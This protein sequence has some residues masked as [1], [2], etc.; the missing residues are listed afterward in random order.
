MYTVVDGGYCVDLY[1]TRKAVS[2]A[3]GGEELCFDRDEPEAL[4]S[5]NLIAN[6]L[7]T[8]RIVWLYEPGANDWK[9][10][11]EKHDRAKG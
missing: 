6:K 8:D 10:R 2:G 9:Y 11:I 4:A 5:P 1:R 7:A 3:F